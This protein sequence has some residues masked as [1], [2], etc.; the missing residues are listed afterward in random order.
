MSK[1]LFFVGLVIALLLGYLCIYNKKEDI[2]ADIARRVTHAVRGDN[3]NDPLARTVGIHVNGRDVTLSGYVLDDQVKEDLGQRVYSVWGV[4]RV[5]NRLEVTVPEPMPLEDSSGDVFFEAPIESAPVAE[6][7]YEESGFEEPPATQA[8]EPVFD[9]V[10]S[11][12]VD[13]PKPEE[14]EITEPVKIEEPSSS[15]EELLPV[16]ESPAEQP[17]IKSLIEEAPKTEVPVAALIEAEILPEAQDVE[18]VHI[19]EVQEIAPVETVSPVVLTPVPVEAPPQEKPA[20]PHKQ[21]ISTKAAVQAL[22]KPTQESVTQSQACEQAFA[23]LLD[24]EKIIFASGS[25]EINSQS[26]NVLDR[27]AREAKN[28]PNSLIL[29]EGYA[30][31]SSDAGKNVML[32]KARAGAVVDYLLGKGVVQPLKFIGR[33]A[34][35]ASGTGAKSSSIGFKVQPIRR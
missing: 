5:V 34:P 16:V 28:C 25:S 21:V 19:E 4:R 31:D 35:N 24:Q 14:F 20:A 26:Y 30:N 10:E 12:I 32:S 29:V 13:Q 18:E 9:I 6:S 33:G 22:Q 27:I 23:A 17:E 3:L 8:P 1:Y 11:L 7:V 2:Q 15:I